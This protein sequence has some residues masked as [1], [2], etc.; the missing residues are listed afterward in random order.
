MLLV[1]AYRRAT[2]QEATH[3][4][5]LRAP[6]AQQVCR[7]LLHNPTLCLKECKICL[8][9]MYFWKAGLIY[10]FAYV[11]WQY[12]PQLMLQCQVAGE[13]LTV[14]GHSP[15]ISFPL[16]DRCYMK[17]VWNL[18]PVRSASVLNTSRTEM[19]A[20]SSGWSQSFHFEHLYSSVKEIC[21]F[22]HFFD[23]FLSPT[24]VPCPTCCPC[25]AVPVSRREKVVVFLLCSKDFWWRWLRVMVQC[26]Q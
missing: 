3:Q 10:T 21:N 16:C 24:C 22:L 20:L 14:A 18:K 12:L 23:V 9:I 15:K 25:S 11:G 6:A 4:Y 5:I 17:D 19:S 7:I 26:C 8:Y 13:V 1:P 2:W